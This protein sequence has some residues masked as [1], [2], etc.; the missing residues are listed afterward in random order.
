M[1]KIVR[2]RSKPHI[3]TIPFLSFECTKKETK[4]LGPIFKCSSLLIRVSAL[5]C[6]ADHKQAFMRLKT[7]ITIIVTVGIVPAHS[8]GYST[9]RIK[10]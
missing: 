8:R 3:P 10:N 5:T 9:S 7:I 6:L 1:I 2:K 4:I